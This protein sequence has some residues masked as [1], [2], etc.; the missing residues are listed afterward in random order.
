MMYQ[1]DRITSN[2]IKTTAYTLSLPC[3]C[4]AV[5][6]NLVACSKSTPSRSTIESHCLSK[7]TEKLNTKALERI[8]KG[9]FKDGKS[10]GLLKVDQLSPKAFAE[11]TSSATASS[12]TQEFIFVDQQNKPIRLVRTAQNGGI[13]LKGGNIVTPHVQCKVV[14]GLFKGKVM[15]DSVKVILANQDGL[16]RKMREYETLVR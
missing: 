8:E 11:G 2:K 10:Y 5:C 16:Q 1:T 4:L 15:K 9:F 14:W 3:F 12:Y 6:F 7:A 13:D